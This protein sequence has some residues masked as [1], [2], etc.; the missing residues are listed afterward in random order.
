MVATLP[1]GAEFSQQAR[2]LVKS[3]VRR[4][5]QVES[6]L[7]GVLKLLQYAT[8]RLGRKIALMIIWVV[9]VAVSLQPVNQSV[10]GNAETQVC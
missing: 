6:L 10:F 9:L 7:T 3:Y 2:R 5:S 4:V 1:L 8:E